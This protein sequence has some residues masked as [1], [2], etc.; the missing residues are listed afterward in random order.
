MKKVIILLA[1]VAI[2]FTI[3]GQNNEV[4]EF[5]AVYYKNGFNGGI[6]LHS[7]GWGIGLQYL[8]NR[9]VNR[10]LIVNLDITTLK[11]PKETKVINPGYDGAKPYIFGKINS[12]IA[13]RPG[14]GGQFIIADKENPIGI[15]INTNII[16]GVNVALLKPVYLEILHNTDPLTPWSEKKTERYDPKHNANQNNQGNIYGGASYFRGF[17]DIST[18]LGAFGKLGLNFEWNDFE[19]NYKFLEVGVIVDAFPERLPIFA[20]IENKYIFTN[21]YLNFSFGKRW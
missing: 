14:I 19:S 4:N 15:R 9:N 6:I 2:C 1:F 5:T 8:A 12:I 13:L 18:Q 11:H 21:L 10:N 20:Y 17:S 16:A 3:S 7:N